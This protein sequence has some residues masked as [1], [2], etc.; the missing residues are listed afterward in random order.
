MKRILIFAGAGIALLLV[1]LAALPYF[2]PSSVYRTQ[3]EKAATGALGRDVN[4]GGD[5]SISVFPVI[6]A[7][8][9]DVTVANPED[10]DDPHMIEAGAL[11]G[12]VKI[13]PLFTRRVEI[14]ELSFEDASVTLTRLENGEVNWALGAPDAGDEPDGETQAGSP[15]SASIS[16]ASLRNASLVYDDRQSGKRYELRDLDLEASLRGETEPLTAKARGRFQ[17]EVFNIDLTV[18]TP[19]TLMDQRATQIDFELG[20][21]LGNA[22]FDGSLENADTMQLDGRFSASLPQIAALTDFLQIETPIDTKP[23][24]GIEARGSVSG[25]VPNLALIFDE[26]ALSGDGLNAKYGGRVTLSGTPEFDG[27]A[28]IAIRNVS[29]FVE[30]L[31]L[32]I[33]Q[34]AAFQQVSFSGHVAGPADAM[35]LSGIEARTSS[36]SLTASYEGNVSTAGNGKLDG[37]FN[38]ESPQLGRLL[39]HFGIVVPEDETFS[40]ARL[41]GDLAGSFMAPSIENGTYK[42]DKTEASGALSADLTGERP[43]LRADLDMKTL[44]ITPF[45]G[46]AEQPRK[47]TNGWSDEPLNL[48]G[49]NLANADLKLAAETIKIGDISLANADLAATLNNGRLDAN[50]N[51]FSSFGGDWQ[52]K[53]TVDASASQPRLAF[54]MGANSVSAESLLGTLAGF[55]RL[56]GTG[57]F[58]VDVTSQGASLRQIVSAL[59]GTA[60]L[61][62]ADGAL[63][64]LNLGQLFR[65]ASSLKDALTTGNLDMTSLKSVVSPEAE[66]DFTSFKGS[67]AMSDGVANVQSLSLANSVMD[68]TG[69]GEINLGGR[70]LDLKLTPAIDKTG[71]GNAS[72]VQLNGIPVPLRISGSWASPSFAPDLSA[73][74]SALTSELRNAAGKAIGQ[75]LEGELGAIISGAISGQTPGSSA[76]NKQNS[77]SGEAPASDSPEEE[78]KPSREEDAIKDAIGAI[79]GPRKTEEAPN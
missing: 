78:G 4:V 41:A 29:G 19:K 14:G 58:A 12:S 73:V 20:S 62:L 65:S 46:A 69:S 71:Q 13:W 27:D 48:D 33:E 72:T 68:V 75:D 24:G 34:L 51:R 31:G 16:R 54:A 3:I 26:L 39:E 38:A 77:D 6:S 5:V 10:F 63:S 57:R 25:T 18:N 36:P 1:I 11:R 60:E 40:S 7:S 35:D 44:D 43:L 23:L 76:D 37:R 79:F 42:I 15:F 28:N 45:I 55:D 8:V 9:E 64:G 52:G 59:D 53:A 22:R 66:T 56:K 49:L 47:E 21:D 2:I 30:S 32:S 67:L 17:E 50:L 70:T 61:D 74:Q